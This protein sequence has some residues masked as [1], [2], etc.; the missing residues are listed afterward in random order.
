MGSPMNLRL[1][2]RSWAIEVCSSITK[3]ASSADSTIKSAG[4]EHG[5]RDSAGALFPDVIL[6][7]DGAQA[8]VVQ[9]WELKLPDT[10][11]E[12]SSLLENAER[13]ARAL[14]LASFLV[15]NVN[16]A[17]LYSISDAGRVKVKGWALAIQVN[18]ESVATSPWR[19]LLHEMLVDISEF[20]SRGT[21]RLTSPIDTI[22][23]ATFAGFVTRHLA[24][25]KEALEY[26]YAT[27]QRLRDSIDLW[28]NEQ[29]YEHVNNIKFEVLANEI[30]VSWLSKFLLAHAIRHTSINAGRVDDIIATTSVVLAQQVFQE[31]SE[32]S[33][34]L[35][36]FHKQMGEESIP[37]QAWEDLVEINKLLGG[38]LVRDMD[39][40]ILQQLLN[41]PRLSARRFAGQFAT[42]PI[43]ASFIVAL[44]G[45]SPTSTILD[46]CVGTGTLARAAFLELRRLGVAATNAT[47]NIWASDKFRGPLRL[48]TLALSTHENRSH[49]LNIF[50]HD[51]ATLSPMEPI[52][53]VDPDT[54]KWVVRQLPEFDV[55]I[56]NL[57]FVRQEDVDKANPG[58]REAI[59]EDLATRGITISGK[60]DLFGY[61]T[62]ALRNVV[63]PGGVV[64]LLTSNS[65]MASEW[66]ISFIEGLERFYKLR[67]VIGSGMGRWFS[68]V[69][70]AT[71]IIVLEKRSGPVS[72]EEIDSEVT[73]YAVLQD[74]IENLCKEDILQDAQILA[75]QIRS[76]ITVEKTVKC[77]SVSTQKRRRM[78]AAGTSFTTLFADTTWADAILPLLSPISEHFRVGRGERRGWD[79]LF[80]PN[81][82]HRIEEEYLVPA[83]LSSRSAQLI[84]EPDGLAFCCSESVAGLTAKKH[85]G[86]LNWIS[87]FT[88]A[89]NRIG[90]PLPDVLAQRGRHWY[91]MNRDSTADLV[92][93][94]NPHTRLFVARLKTPAV[95]NQRLITLRANKQTDIDLCHALLNSSVGV[96][97]LEASGFGRGEGV[98]DLRSDSVKNR[99]RMLDPNRISSK[100]RLK[101]LKAFAPL[102]GR[103]VLD[104]TLEMCENDRFTFDRA[105]GEV[106]GFSSYVD[107]VRKAS[108]EIM[109]IRLL[110][111]QA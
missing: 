87:R 111:S 48:A 16:N 105:I 68:E 91:E 3:W 54:G 15:W 46:P 99:M 59:Q 40:S 4:G 61:L 33:D 52:S 58:V 79:E 21:I 11:I 6:F 13:K 74:K 18:R 92:I 94:M 109:S 78:T 69:K 22:T 80:Y 41:I 10:S 66:G 25:T 37:A 82:D 19:E 1:T 44:A 75:A 9:G 43:V 50:Q 89:Q 45:L 86:A 84:A 31:I 60:S 81:G 85:L 8:M 97:L 90:R 36:V 108:I 20:I 2:E 104:L 49:I 39:A 65:W 101:I 30:L 93:P 7:G 28:W 62:F 42:P 88:N 23:S 77:F 95:V 76:S 107:A 57:P 34:F 24:S 100:D 26:F 38:A 73:T 53:L 110:A 71:T 55:L 103:S 51:A 98:L 32:T 102:K 47:A 29:K 14:G 72:A 70:I 67:Y 83:L 106:F 27:D 17:V 35:N 64:V 63:K 56:S 5:M 96:L 12:D